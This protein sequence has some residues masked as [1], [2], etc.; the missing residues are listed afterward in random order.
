MF[1]VS[2]AEAAAIRRAYEESGEFAAAVELRQHF[3]GISN[4]DPAGR[5]SKIADNPDL[6]QT[7]WSR[8]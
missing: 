7:G 4:R 6:T 5:K 1:M 8:R 2:E 3:P